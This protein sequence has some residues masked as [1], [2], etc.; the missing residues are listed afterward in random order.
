M[1]HPLIAVAG[2]ICLDVIPTFL[3][4]PTSLQEFLVPGKLTRV[5]PV[6]ISTGGAVSNTGLALHRLGVPV[7]LLGKI[8]GDQ[9]GEAILEVLRRHD[10]ALAEGMIVSQN[11]SSSYTIVINPPGIDRIFL[12]DPGPND[13]FG[14]DD[15][16]LEAL[17]GIRIFHF[18]YPPLV[19]RM[20]LNGGAE[21]VA[22][23]RGVKAAGITTSLDMSLP[24]PNSEAGRVDWLALLVTVLPHVDIFVPS[25][26]EL[27]F[28]MD[29][30]RFAEE[31]T[32]QQTIELP[33]LRG[34]ADRLLAMG[35]AI[36]MI[37]L[38]EQ[39]AYL[40]TTEDLTRLQRMGSGIP[41]DLENWCGRELYE[42]SFQVTVVGTTGAGDC[43]I[44]GLLTALLQGLRV[45]EALNVAVAV[46]ACSVERADA[47]SG[48]PDW[49][50]V[51]ARINKGWE[52]NNNGFRKQQI[53][54][55][56]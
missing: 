1:S 38:G 35:V 18:G 25:I 53:Q 28:M 6:V 2:H 4:A 31:R 45:E 23:M 48:V 49:D 3:T 50:A 12:H 46:G 29:R 10:P 8:G 21:L 11:E 56:P 20:Y 14:A 16:R 39:G 32:A 33:L 52:K 5:G 9:F 19:R 27:L 44:A 51:L 22:L 55:A 47:T 36:V 54:D 26:D 7:K 13:T 37:K 43:T 34:L 40:R 17:A 15:I 42:P 30:E 41:F 24:D